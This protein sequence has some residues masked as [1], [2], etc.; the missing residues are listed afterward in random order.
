MAEK[1]SSSTSRSPRRQTPDSL[2]KSPNRKTTINYLDMLLVEEDVSQ[3][4]CQNLKPPPLNPQWWD[5][6]F[7][8]PRFSPILEVEVGNFWL[9]KKFCV[10]FCL[11]QDLI[12][13]HQSTLNKLSVELSKKIMSTNGTECEVD[14]IIEVSL[15]LNVRNNIILFYLSVV[16]KKSATFNL[17]NAGK[18]FSRCSRNW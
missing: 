5:L 13:S 16:L 11:I 6:W 12:A 14:I 7:K 3:L 17:R 15:Y 18:I 1:N 4:I 2:Q 9:C 10:F 8:L